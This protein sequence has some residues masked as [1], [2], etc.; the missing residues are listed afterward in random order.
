M[1]LLLADYA[2]GADARARE[3]LWWKAEGEPF[4]VVLRRAALSTLEDGRRHSH[5][6][7][8]PVAVLQT[9]AE[10]LIGVGSHLEAAPRFH[11]LLEYVQTLYR[12]I[13]G[14]GELLAY[15]SAERIRHRLN[16]VS[17]HLVYLHAGTRVGARRLL[18]G[19]IPRNE[20]WRLMRIQIP[21]PLRVLDNHELEDFLCRYKD[22]L[23]LSP[24]DARVALNTR[25]RRTCGPFQRQP[26]RC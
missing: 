6:S 24:E 15:D 1:E 20:A 25:R 12:P 26:A 10:A 7:R 3:A 18:G 2:M 13:W 23:M 9:C 21:R 8:I 14:A 4:E 5:Q 19:R 22:E 17:E 16:L 11:D